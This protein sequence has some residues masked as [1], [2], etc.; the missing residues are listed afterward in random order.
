MVNSIW[1]DLLG[2]QVH[3]VGTRYRTRVIEY[4]AGEPLILLHGGGGHAE[5]YSR[6]VVRLGQHDREVIAFLKGQ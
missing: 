6:N 1:V 5:A 3:Y 2:C 4:G